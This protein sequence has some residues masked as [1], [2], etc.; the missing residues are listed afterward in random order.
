[1]P[2]DEVVLFDSPFITVLEFPWRENQP[3][4]VVRPRTGK[5]SSVIAIAP[6]KEG[7]AKV[8]LLQQE[9]PPIFGKTW[10]MPAGGVDE[11]E[12]ELVGAAREFSEETGVPVTAEDLTPIGYVF[13]N[14]A[15]ADETIS[16]YA[17]LLPEDFD[18]D[19]VKVQ[20]NEILDYKWLP[21]SEAIRRSIEDPHY[22]SLVATS[23]LR[24]HYQGLIEV[25]LPTR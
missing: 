10:E 4:T 22:S 24:A 23:I 11:G 15:F 21:V 1:M 17:A 8:L 20:E 9:R 6:Q 16:I 12:S 5:A 3:Y 25:T 19:S 14:P 18:L 2:K 7:E 13:A